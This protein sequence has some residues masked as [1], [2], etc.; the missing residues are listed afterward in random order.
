MQSESVR[1]ARRAL[2][3]LSARAF[4]VWFCRKLLATKDGMSR[5][6]KDEIALALQTDRSTVARADAEIIEAEL[7]TTSRDGRATVYHLQPAPETLTDRLPSPFEDCSGSSNVRE[8]M[9]CQTCHIMDATSSETVQKCHVMDATSSAAVSIGTR[10]RARAGAAEE[11]APER[12]E[13]AGAGARV[14][15]KTNHIPITPVE[16]NSSSS[17]SE[18]PPSAPRDDDDEGSAVGERS[19]ED[20]AAF[21]SLLALNVDERVAAQLL[22]KFGAERVSRNVVFARAAHAKKPKANLGAYTAAIVADDPAGRNAEARAKMRERT[23]ER[24]AAAKNASQAERLAEAQRINAEA[25]KRI[26]QERDQ[27][28]AIRAAIDIIERA[29]EAQRAAALETLI[30]QAQSDFERGLIRRRGLTN[31]TCAVRAAAL[32]Q[33]KQP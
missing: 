16:V 19:A 15:R 18:F 4:Q 3:T 21:D 14:A 2:S 30:I 17:S 11:R 27:A 5:T 31:R 12:E 33:G 13:P 6:N 28:N 7:M 29:T 24:S 9:I 32:I 22:R 8:S 20:Q 1:T 10:A 26:Q 25:Q 23:A